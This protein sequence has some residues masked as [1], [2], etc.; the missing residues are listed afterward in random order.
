MDRVVWLLL[1]V[2]LFLMAGCAK[3]PEEKEIKKS[4]E[5]ITIRLEGEV[6]PS[7]EE[8]ILAPMDGTVESIYVDVGDRVSRGELLMRFETTVTRYD[9]DRTQQELEYL[10]SLREFFKK[11]RKG[12]VTKAMVNV[13]RLNLEKLAQLRSKGYSSDQELN[14][15][16]MV[17]ASSLHSKYTEEENKIERI[18]MLDERIATVKSE[19]MKLQHLISLSEV[20]S[21]IGGI[22]SQIK[23]QRGDY[24]SKGSPLGTISNIDTVIV[25]AGIAAGLLP[26]IKKGKDVKIDFITTPPYSVK[27]KISR[28]VL[29][30]DPNFGRMTAEIE[31]P[32]KNYIL[33]TGTKALVTVYLTKEEQEFIKKNFIDNPNKTVYE[34]KSKNY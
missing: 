28:V 4:R 30:V 6:F 13:A 7:Q 34:V 24:V 1:S 22:V 21:E 3:S 11:S 12:E 31:V 5:G 32:N 26:F 16:K 20:R 29:V 10:T 25:K 9:L 2:L 19:L 14:S 27:A 8:E 33:Q 18:R 17:Y 15:A 23:T